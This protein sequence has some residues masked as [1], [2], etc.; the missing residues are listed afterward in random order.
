MNKGFMSPKIWYFDVFCRKIDLFE[1][2][3]FGLATST[4]FGGYGIM[5]SNS[6]G[7]GHGIPLMQAK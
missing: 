1:L 6:S 5:A 4:F 7:N 2:N 3:S